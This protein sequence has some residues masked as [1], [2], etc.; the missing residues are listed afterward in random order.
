MSPKPTL[1]LTTEQGNWSV[2]SRSSHDLKLFQ[3]KIALQG[4]A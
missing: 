1:S 4:S 2:A 3:E